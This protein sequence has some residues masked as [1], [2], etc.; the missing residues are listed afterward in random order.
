MPYVLHTK[1]F[2]QETTAP[3][4]AWA[5]LNVAFGLLV[6]TS[7]VYYAAKAFLQDHVRFFHEADCAE[8]AKFWGNDL[9][10]ADLSNTSR[11]YVEVVLGCCVDG[12]T[13]GN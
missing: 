1:I 11:A 9:W 3:A 6:S 5:A 13:C 7:G 2:W 10:G 12:A 4:L 8:G